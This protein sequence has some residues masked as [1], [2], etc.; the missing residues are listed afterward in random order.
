MGKGMV[1]SGVVHD[2]TDW[3]R[4]DPAAWWQP[5]DHGT[6]PRAETISILCGHWVAGEAGTNTY[7]DDGPRVVHAMKART[8]VKDVGIHF[9]IGACGESDAEAPIWQTA[10][11]GIVSTVHVGK[12]VVNERSIGVEIVSAGLPGPADV[13]HRP[14][15]ACHY[16][17]R[18]V[19][20]LAFYP[21]QLA[22]WMRLA[23]FLASLDGD[24]G[25]SIKRQTPADVQHQFSIGD[26]RKF[27]GMMEHFMTPGTTKIDAGAMLIG[28]AQRRGWTP[29]GR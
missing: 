18:V 29:V 12:G 15:V 7:D 3:V 9:V 24:A 20:C 19:K 10:D 1:I 8:D 21:G 2:D 13:R 27:S 26:V 22:T 17:G 25:V 11:F 28:E 4:R 16:L 5:G 14:Q 23:E 6:R